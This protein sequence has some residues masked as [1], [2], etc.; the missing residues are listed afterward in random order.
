MTLHESLKQLVAQFGQTVVSEQRLANLVADINGYEECPAMKQVFRGLVKDGYAQ[1][2]FAAYE[3]NPADA[4]A[5][6]SNLS[7]EFAV[8]S[9]FKPELTT[10]GFDCIL[11]AL[12][13]TDSI[14]EPLFNGFDPTSKGDADLLDNLPGRLESLKKQYLDL[15]DN[16]VV[17][18]H[19]ALA[20]APA[21]YTTDSLNKLYAV[22]ARMAAI[23][24]QM[25]EAAPSEWCKNKRTHKLADLHNIQKNE[26]TKANEA[27]AR[28][29]KRRVSLITGIGIAASILVSAIGMFIAYSGSA[30]ERAQFYAAIQRGEESIA[31]A[32]YQTGFQ[33]FDEAK[34]NYS[35]FMASFYQNEAEQHKLDNI[36]RMVREANSLISQD[37]LGSAD[38]ILSSVPKNVLLSDAKR[39]KQVD[40][41]YSLLNNTRTTL[42]NQFLA[43]ILANNGHLDAEHKKKLE[44]LL[45][46]MPDEYW[47]NTIAQKDKEKAKHKKGTSAKPSSPQ[48]EANEAAK[49]VE[50]ATPPQPEIDLAKEA[51]ALM[52]NM[53]AN[54]GK[55]DAQGKAKLDALIKEYPNDHWLNVIKKKEEQQ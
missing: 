33:L 18:P 46:D 1:K 49:A 4:I 19:D 29:N 7:K 34:A 44:A 43:N 23:A 47:L 2:L 45:A 53:A 51:Q 42:F 32:D 48:V 6:A 14:S 16:L 41:A 40:D 54:G 50:P 27:E 9:N 52:A 28:A 10:Y 37:L 8:A 5:K 12:G 3:Q 22:E 38:A 24:Q 13:C 26:A 55:L 36:D 20:D 35:G 31:N 17:L 25:G 21:H 30:E 39:R 11:W 15:L